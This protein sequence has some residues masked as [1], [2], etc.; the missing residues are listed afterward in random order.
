M[1]GNGHVPFL[2]GGMMVPSSCYPTVSGTAGIATSPE[3]LVQALM[4]LHNYGCSIRQSFITPESSRSL[5][6]VAV[7]SRHLP[8]NRRISPPLLPRASL[9]LY[10]NE[11]HIN[12]CRW[13]FPIGTVLSFTFTVVLENKEYTTI[14]RYIEG[15]M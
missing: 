10:R 11:H 9:I 8:K 2:G 1:L 14:I 7:R 4:C 6:L 5:R 13:Y 15:T 3:A 12:T